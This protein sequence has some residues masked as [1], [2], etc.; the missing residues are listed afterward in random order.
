MAEQ[1][2]GVVVPVS[3]FVLLLTVLVWMLTKGGR[4]GG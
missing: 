2:I 3:A 1:F 4:R